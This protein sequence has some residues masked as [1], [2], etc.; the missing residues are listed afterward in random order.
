M[1]FNPIQCKVF[2]TTCR[3]YIE[4]DPVTNKF[5]HPDTGDL[6]PLSTFLDEPGRFHV[7]RWTGRYTNGGEKIFLGD[8][9][10]SPNL[11]RGFVTEQ[12]ATVVVVFPD[13]HTPTLDAVLDD[14]KDVE[15]VD[16]VGQPPSLLVIWTP[17]SG[18][19]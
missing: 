13:S 2:D 8:Y 12:G 19:V 14:Q 9:L 1:F 7:L 5:V 4:G 17:P 15:H 3:T 6:E 18:Y 11:G 10:F 16:G